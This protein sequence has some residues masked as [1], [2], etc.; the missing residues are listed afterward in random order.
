MRAVSV[1]AIRKV[2]VVTKD[3]ESV[4]KVASKKPTVEL[5]ATP[6]FFPVFVSPTVDV[7]DG[8]KLLMG[9]SATGTGHSSVGIVSND[10]E[11]ALMG[12][13]SLTLQNTNAVLLLP[14]L[15]R[16]QPSFPIFL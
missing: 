6:Y 3:A 9:L 14:L 1:E 7:V 2:A 5:L 8:K 15:N 16:K 12:K 10:L 11:T 4:G 13:L